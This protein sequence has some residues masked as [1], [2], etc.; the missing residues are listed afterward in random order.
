MLRLVYGITF[1]VDLWLSAFLAAVPPKATGTPPERVGAKLQNDGKD[2][3]SEAEASK[4]QHAEY[5]RQMRERSLKSS[6]RAAGSEE[7]T[8]AQLN[9]IP[10]LYSADV[11]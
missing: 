11:P 7:K 9:E 8:A 4:K 6:V 5:V 3:P 10:L 2:N 1:V